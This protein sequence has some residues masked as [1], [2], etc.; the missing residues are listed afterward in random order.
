MSIKEKT[1]KREYDRSV[2]TFYDA[3]EDEGD[4][5]VVKIWKKKK[6]GHWLRII[7]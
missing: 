4:K 6:Q 2:S 1:K 3:I 7:G 5:I